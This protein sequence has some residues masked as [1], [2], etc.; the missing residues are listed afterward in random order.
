MGGGSDITGY[1][2][3]IRDV[4]R[5][6]QYVPIRTKLG[7]L[8]ASLTLSQGLVGGKQYC[9]KVGGLNNVTETNSLGQSP[10]LSDAVCA[11]AASTPDPPLSV[12]ALMPARGQVRA[13]WPASYNNG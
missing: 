7:P 8:R 4:A 10:T 12:Y 13:E 9:F 1:R 3:Y 5:S 6:H 2:V 11:Y